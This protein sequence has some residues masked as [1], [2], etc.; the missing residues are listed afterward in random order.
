MAIGGG[1]S[2]VGI[3]IALLYVFLGGNPND[4]GGFT[5][6]TGQG[7]VSDDTAQAD[8]NDRCVTGA[9][10][11][12]YADCR[13]LGAVESLDAFWSAQMPAA[14]FAY[15]Q[16]GV[17]V[18]DQTTSSACGQASSS[19]GPFYCP[20][21]QT[22]YVDVTFY[23]S[24][25]QFGFEDGPLAEMYVIAHEY[26][27]HIENL[28]GVFDVADRSGS[29][30]DSD[31]VKVEL[32]ADCLAGNWMGYAAT[33]PDPETGQPFL[34]PI[35]EAQLNNALAA[36][37]SVG[38]DRI[39]ETVQ[40]QAQPHTFTHGTSEQRIEFVKRGYE[41]GTVAACDLFGVTQR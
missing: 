28:V 41:Y 34:K 26:A 13:V 2:I 22:M 9:D 38:D 27:H 32:M 23:D 10:A 1:G 37:G 24:L 35:T 6:G 18:F 19:T 5:T 36:A 14:G 12:E 21:D 40:G 15:Q 16:P 39:Q 17:V 4:L 3:I 33:V 8:F 31:S 25:E 29:G 20:A 11:N 30:A 7:A